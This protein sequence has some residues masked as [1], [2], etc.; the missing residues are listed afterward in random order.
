MSEWRHVLLLDEGPQLTRLSARE[1]RFAGYCLRAEL[2]AVAG[3]PGRGVTV[4]GVGMG[5]VRPAAV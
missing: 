1:S 5:R 3:A 4:L 2:S